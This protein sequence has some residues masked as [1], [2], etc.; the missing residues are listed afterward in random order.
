MSSRRRFTAKQVCEAVGG[1]GG[2]KLAVA[3]NLECDRHTVD[4]YEKWYKSVRK[5]LKQERE[6]VTDIAE[7]VLVTNIVMAAQEQKETK[8]PVD[9]SDAKWYLARI[10]K[11][12]GYTEKRE[13]D[14]TTDG[15]K[16]PQPVIMLPPVD[17]ETG[18]VK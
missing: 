17:R 3:R 8:R 2:I 15:E 9:A 6:K 16:W 10:G 14:I 5:A 18:G 1:T 4:R 13:T 7:T 11:D 12:R